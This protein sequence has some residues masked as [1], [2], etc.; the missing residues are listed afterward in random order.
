MNH[1]M[2]MMA[3][4]FVALLL[5]ACSKDKADSG[6]TS[7][8]IGDAESDAPS[9]A[10]KPEAC[11]AG[12]PG[13]KL[14]KLA[15]PDGTGYCMDQREVTA[16]EYVTFAKAMAGKTGGQIEACAWNTRY[17]PKLI[18]PHDGQM[19]G[20]DGYCMA[21]EYDPVKH[22]DRAVAC[23][24]WCDAA[25]YCA[26]AGKRLCGKVGGGTATLAGIN[27]PAQSEWTNACTQGGKTKYPWGDSYAPGTCV[28]PVKIQQQGEAAKDVTG[29]ASSACHGALEGF[30]EVYDLVGSV[31]EWTA[32]CESPGKGCAI[33][34]YGSMS[35]PD[36]PMSCDAV[37]P[38]TTTDTHY[39]IGFRCCADLV[40][41][42]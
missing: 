10:A 11:P 41:G 42:K 34:G 26:W 19:V 6:I 29:T 1:R 31:Q 12:L 30:A 14:V 32:E 38:A 33:H 5:A 35:S 16:G 37:G 18:P 2:A 40:S 21:E 13:P 25:A 7:E 9:D 15:A 28:D 24:D 17:E 27:D 23:V 36:V 3:P 4:A 22:P 39:E 20:M 8:P